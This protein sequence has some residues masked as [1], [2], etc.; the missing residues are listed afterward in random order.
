MAAT[1]LRKEM[2]FACAERCAAQQ[3]NHSNTLI[4]SVIHIDKLCSIL[5]SL[6]RQHSFHFKKRFFFAR[7]AGREQPAIRSDV[8]CLLFRFTL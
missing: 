8:I 7:F 5:M 3:A 1:E 2:L 4:V 6:Q